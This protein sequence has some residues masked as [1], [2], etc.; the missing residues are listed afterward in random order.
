MNDLIQRLRRCAELDPRARICRECEEAAT[1][2]ESQQAR[3]H[4]LTEALRIDRDE[5]DLIRS[6][7]LGH[8]PSLARNDGLR[9]ANDLLARMDKARMD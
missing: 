7:L 6:V 1:A 3:I 4:T 5:V 9:A 2:L 8:P